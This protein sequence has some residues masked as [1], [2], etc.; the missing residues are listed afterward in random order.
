MTNVLYFKL[1]V[2]NFRKSNYKSVFERLKILAAD[3]YV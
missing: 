2:N 3:A 1:F